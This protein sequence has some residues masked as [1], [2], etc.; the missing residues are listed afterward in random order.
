MA[1]K[2]T[3]FVRTDAREYTLV[4]TINI[5]KEV[6]P[7]HSLLMKEQR[8]DTVRTQT[9]LFS[10]KSKKPGEIDLILQN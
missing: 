5:L 4:T 8:V 3:I 9:E 7:Y 10:N 1:D 2:S 6:F